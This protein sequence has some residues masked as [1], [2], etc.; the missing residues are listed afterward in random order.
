MRYLERGPPRYQKIWLELQA[1][2]WNRPEL[3]ERARARER[4]VAR[5]AHR[6]V[7]AAAT[8]AT[9]SRLPL[10]AL[11]TLVM[12]FN[13]G[14]IA[15]A[16][17]GGIDDRPRRAARLDRRD[18]SMATLTAAERGARADARALPRRVGLRRARRRRA[19]LRGLRRGRADGPAPADVVDHPLAALED[20]DPVPRAPLPR[21]HLRRARQRPLRPPGRAGVRRARVRRRRARRHGRDRRPSAPC[22]S[23]SR[24][25]RSAAL[26]LAAEHPERVGAPSSSPR[27]CRSASRRAERDEST[28]RRASS[29]PTRA[30]RSTTAT[31]GCATTAASSSS[32]SRR[33][34]PSRTRR[35]RS[36]TASAG[37]SRR[38]PRR[39]IA[40]HARAS[41]STPDAHAR[42]VPAA[43]AARCS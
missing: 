11:V 2:A 13:Q 37:G 24:W 31:T 42:A 1:L 17:L 9:G 29:T 16:A 3:R 14:I 18:G 33:C 39:S 27:A 23:R 21:R 20:A 36:R 28:L 5:G 40:T 12:T 26:L 43:S 7:R 35:S 22:S 32:S 10:E 38:R 25:A 41:G 15:R 34:S 8:R 19:L 30:G 4:R 6:G